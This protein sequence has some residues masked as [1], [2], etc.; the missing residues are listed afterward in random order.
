MLIVAFMLGCT[1]STS[2]ETSDNPTNLKFKAENVMFRDNKVKASDEFTD[3]KV[4]ADDVVLNNTNTSLTADNVQGAFEETQP[5]LSEI[6]VGEWNVKAYVGKNDD[7]SE[8]KTGTITFNADKTFSFTG[9]GQEFASGITG[10]ATPLNYN[11]YEDSLLNMTC[12]SGEIIKSPVRD[13]TTITV[14]KLISKTPNNQ[15]LENIFVLIKK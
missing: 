9:I 13:F 4:Y 10:D 11:I 6:I 2:G 14:N 3:Q 5:K 8:I 7:Y 1:I 15:G 12:Q